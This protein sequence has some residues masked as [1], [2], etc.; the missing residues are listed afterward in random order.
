M[1][2]HPWAEV[3]SPDLQVLT[4][5][6]ALRQVG[7]H[8]Q[9]VV[10]R[11]QAIEHTMGVVVLEAADTEFGRVERGDRQGI[12]DPQGRAFGGPR[13]CETGRQG[14]RASRGKNG[15]ARESRTR[16]SIAHGEAPLFL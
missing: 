7:Y 1:E 3:E 15:P 11:C 2:F 9:L 8:L 13:R 6:P 10:L 16:Q 14:S 4:G 5:V 12:G